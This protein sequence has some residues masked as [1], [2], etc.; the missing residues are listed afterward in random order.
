MLIEQ[1]P[2]NIT[3]PVITVKRK[4]ICGRI[5]QKTLD[6]EASLATYFQES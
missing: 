4:D 3:P 2:T 1:Y 5:R 6:T